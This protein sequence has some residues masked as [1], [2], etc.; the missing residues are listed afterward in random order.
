MLMVFL[1]KLLKAPFN[2]QL[3]GKVGRICTSI[4]LWFIIK[5][6][7]QRLSEAQDWIVFIFVQNLL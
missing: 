1:Y 4:V 5:T 3:C 7:C 6:Y 2:D